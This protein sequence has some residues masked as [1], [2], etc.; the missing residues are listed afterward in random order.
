MELASEAASAALTALPISEDRDAVVA[1]LGRATTELDAAI[2]AAR[3]AGVE[4]ADIEH[5]RSHVLQPSKRAHHRY[6]EAKAQL[7][8]MIGRARTLATERF[9]SRDAKKSLAS[10]LERTIELGEKAHLPA[11]LIAA[12]RAFVMPLLVTGLSAATLQKAE[13]AV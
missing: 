5:V 2:E 4:R 8:E 3:Q 12:A 11:K 13:L 9:G 6:Q 7:N 10:Q 1:E